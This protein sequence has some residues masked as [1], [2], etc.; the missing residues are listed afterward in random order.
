MIH[1][2]TPDNLV[3]VLLTVCTLVSATLLTLR[4]EGR[5]PPSVMS[6]GSLRLREGSGAS[7]HE[8]VGGRAR[9]VRG[10]DFRFEHLHGLLTATAILLL[11]A[12]PG[13]VEVHRPTLMIVYGI[14]AA[15]I[16]A[17]TK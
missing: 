16:I 14:V 10:R 12:G 15:V 8:L 9:Y 3:P 1:S 17:C 5:E 2:P 7:R 13:V 11:V 4:A 6:E